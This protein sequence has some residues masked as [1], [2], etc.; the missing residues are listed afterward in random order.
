[1][2]SAA[3]RSGHGAV[4]RIEH[5]AATAAVPGSVVVVVVLEVVLE[6]VL[7]VV[8]GVVVLVVGGVVVDDD[9][10]SSPEYRRPS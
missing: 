1:M 4:C 7:V 6:V 3:L 10:A 2:S 9:V 8:L 5:V